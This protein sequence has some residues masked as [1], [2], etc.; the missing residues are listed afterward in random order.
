MKLHVIELLVKLTRIVWTYVGDRDT[1]EL[2]VSVDDAGKVIGQKLDTRNEVALIE[3]TRGQ[4][5]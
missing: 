4:S 2:S 1:V 3:C 5:V